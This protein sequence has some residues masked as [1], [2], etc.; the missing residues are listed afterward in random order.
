LDFSALICVH[1]HP[2]GIGGDM[3][4]IPFTKMS[5]CGND[6]IVI[7]NRQKILETERLGDFIRKVCAP[8]VSVGADGLVLIEPSRQVNFKWRFFNSDGSIAEMCGNAARCVARFAVLKGIAP[9]KLAFETLA[10]I[11][12][13]EVAGRQVKVQMVQP[14]GLKLNIGLPIDGQTH[15]L[16]FLNTGVPHAVRLVE[17]AASAD[18]KGW[19]K[20]IRFHSH[21][22]PGGT[23]ANF[24]QVVDRGHINVRTYERGVEEETLACGTGAVASALIVARMG[25]ADSPVEVQTSGGEIL[26]I[27]FQAKGEGFDR[28]F[29]EGDT[30]VVY[31]GELWEEAYQY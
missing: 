7:D 16:H 11:I 28:V 27:H 10:G 14:T 29:L 17:N 19:G 21:F 2:N 22:Q 13:A 6:F 20:K 1:L 18:V 9:P 31:E 5:G 23:N 3:T 8:K 25:L 4:K 26:K 15:Q 30:R 12:E 24:V